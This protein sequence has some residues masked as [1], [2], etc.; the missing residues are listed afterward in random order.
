M[1]SQQNLK[2]FKKN[3]YIKLK[4]V[5]KKKLLNL[6]IDFA[7]MIE[8]SFRKVFPKK[9]INIT[10]PIKR[11][12]F[13]LNDAVILLEKENHKNLSSLL[14]QISRC[15]SF[16]Q[17]ITDKKITMVVNALLNRNKNQNLYINSNTIRMDIPGITKFV[18]GWHQDH[19]SNIKD[20]NFVQMWLPPFG[21]NN[22]LFDLVP[23]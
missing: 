5:D 22:K 3:G 6:R 21:D 10:N 15:T 11:I 4:C 19:T 1:L 13:F 18:Y 17:V 7:K 20:S 23:I 2:K 16:Y 14:D 9:K 12:N 8:I